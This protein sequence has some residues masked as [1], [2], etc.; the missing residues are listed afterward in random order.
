[1]FTFYL[2]WLLVTHYLTYDFTWTQKQYKN[3]TTFYNKEKYLSMNDVETYNT[4]N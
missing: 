2:S 1:M 3:L 4:N